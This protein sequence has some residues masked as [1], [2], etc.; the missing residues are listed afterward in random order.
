MNRFVLALLFAVSAQAFMMPPAGR[1]AP[2]PLNLISQEEAEKILTHASDCI[3][4]ECALDEV[5]ELLVALKDQQ[6]EL[7]SRVQEIGTLIKSLENVHNSDEREVDEVRE[8]VRA[9]FRIFQMGDKASGNDYP[10]LTKPMGYPG[11]VGK[12][13]TTA[14]DALP[15]KKWKKTSP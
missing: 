3:E 15:P 5:D 4:S 12:G 13:P 7:N 1:I 6:R 9:I 14:Y 10:S 2:R 8:T 11:E